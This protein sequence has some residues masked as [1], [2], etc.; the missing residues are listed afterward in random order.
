MIPRHEME[1][2]HLFEIT[3]ESNDLIEPEKLAYL[4]FVIKALN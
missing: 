3:V 4:R 2:V 1:G